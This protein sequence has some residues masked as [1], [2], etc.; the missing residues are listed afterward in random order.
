MAVDYYFAGAD[1][2]VG[3][4]DQPGFFDPDPDAA[5]TAPT[6]SAGTKIAAVSGWSFK[7]T[8]DYKELYAMDSIKR[9]AVARCKARTEGKLD[10]AK[11]DPTVGTWWAMK[12]LNSA[13]GGT[14]ADTSKFVFFMLWGSIAPQDSANA[15]FG[16]KI[17]N[18]TFNSMPFGASEHEW[19][20]VDLGF[21]ATHFDAVN[22]APTFT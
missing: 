15:I 13:G 14:T 6:W 20:A 12:I 17:Y 7:A 9:L 21:V 8:F 16:A 22:T 5:E 11:F 2:K 19:I 10:F 1:S 18:A 3:V 4:M